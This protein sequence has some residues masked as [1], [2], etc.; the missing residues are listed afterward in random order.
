MLAS[1]CTVRYAQVCPGR[2]KGMAVTLPS[3]STTQPQHLLHD[4][5][6]LGPVSCIRCMWL[7]FQLIRTSP[8]IINI[9]CFFAGAG[10]HVPCNIHAVY[11]YF[12]LLFFRIQLI[13][14]PS[15][16][17]HRF[18]PIFPLREVAR[19]ESIS[20][21]CEGCGRRCRQ[22]WRCSSS[23]PCNIERTRGMQTRG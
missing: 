1:F 18:F 4:G 23:V 11:S 21:A 20:Q 13:L 16:P 10:V 17:D 14:G 3:V 9:S 19:V 7:C 12:S 8:T 5:V 6:A 22:S 2:I 15:Q